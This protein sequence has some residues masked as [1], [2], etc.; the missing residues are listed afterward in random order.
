LAKIKTQEVKTKIE[1]SKKLKPSAKLGLEYQ[2]E[3]LMVDAKVELLSEL[4]KQKVLETNAA[5]QFITKYASS[6]D[7]EMKK[8]ALKIHK[9]IKAEEEKREEK[10][11]EEG[12][13]V[14]AELT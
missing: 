8:R 14:G 4:L 9:E 5:K 6:R 3:K 1:N 12:E 10:E 13:K 2:W 11:P 7:E